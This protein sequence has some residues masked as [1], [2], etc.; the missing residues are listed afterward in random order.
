MPASPALKD[1]KTGRLLARWMSVLLKT[2]GP[3]SMRNTTSK[4][5]RGIGR[6]L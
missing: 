2:G 1:A 6:H 5:K 3:G 4:A